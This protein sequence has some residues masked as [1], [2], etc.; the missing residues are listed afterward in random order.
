MHWEIVSLA[1]FRHVM[2]VYRLND[3]EYRRPLNRTWSAKNATRNGNI[4]NV[5]EADG[6]NNAN[7]EGKGLTVLT[8]GVSEI[9]LPL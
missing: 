5:F 9:W 4:Q 7:K 8:L 3:L 1:L 6:V 2:I